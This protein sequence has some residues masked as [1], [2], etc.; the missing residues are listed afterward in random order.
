[1]LC[2]AWWSWN[3]SLSSRRRIFYNSLLRLL[4]PPKFSSMYTLDNFFYRKMRCSQFLYSFFSS[5]LVHENAFLFFSQYRASLQ[6]SRFILRL[7]SIWSQTIA[8]RRSQRDLFPY[9]RRRSQTIAEPTVAIHFVQRKCHLYSCVVLAG[10]S[11][12]TTWQTSRRKFCCKQ[13]YFFF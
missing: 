12:Q 10:K 11:K 4:S 3:W 8:D 13:I 6:L 9:N 7:V 1:M 5:A 2:A